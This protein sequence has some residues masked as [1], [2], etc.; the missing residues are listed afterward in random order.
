MK[1]SELKGV[2]T[3]K[4]LLEQVKDYEAAKPLELAPDDNVKFLADDDG[5]FV[6]SRKGETTLSPGALDC[7]TTY[8]GIPRA[9]SKKIPVEQ[10]TNLIVPHLN[11]WYK[12]KLSESTMRLL[13]IE[14]NAISVIPKANFEHIKVSQV[15]DTAEHALGKSVA[16]YH[17]PWFGPLSF[18]FSILTS[19]EVEVTKGHIYNSGIRVQHSITGKTSTKISPYLFNQWCTNGATTEHK[20]DTWK[21][22]SGSEDIGVWLTRIIV[23][24]NKLFDE[25]VENL[26]ELC[27]IKVDKDTSTIL[28][29]V[30]QQSRVPPRLQNE[31][32]NTLIDSGAEN[33]Y[34]IYNILT[35]V[36]TH[37]NIFEDHPNSKGILDRVAAHLAHH[38]R[39]CPVCHRQLNGN[40]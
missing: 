16:G 13:T 20:L 8:V 5:V 11:F 32:Q 36:D 19:R 18:Q 2:M 31:V 3:R 12:K 4:Q 22:R 29:S 1:V 23:E 30:L 33:L 40:S 21:R 27:K 6:S 28:N 15:V 39:L 35:Q 24:A 9:Y 38:S 25:E 26:R 34:D 7:L 37:S 17:K 10:F 14:D